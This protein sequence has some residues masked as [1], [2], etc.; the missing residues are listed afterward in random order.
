LNKT[1]F[2]KIKKTESLKPKRGQQVKKNS[3]KMLFA[4]PFEMTIIILFTLILFRKINAVCKPKNRNDLILARDGCLGES[5][6]GNCPIFAARSN[7][8]GCG[9][10]G[11]NGA[12]GDWNVSLVEDMNYMFSS[13]GNFNSDLSKW[14]VGS[15]TDMQYMF[16]QATNFDSDLSKWSVGSVTDM[17]N[18]FYGATNFDSDLSKWS[19]GSVTTMSN[20]FYGAANFNSDLSKWSVGSVTDMSSMF[21]QATKFDPDLSK[22]SVGSVTDMNSMFYQATKFS[23]TLC[24]GSWTESTASKDSMFVGTSSAKIADQPCHCD[25]GTYNDTL[26]NSCSPCPRGRYQDE[27]GY[28]LTECTK[29]CSAGKYSDQQRT[30]SNDDCKSCSPGKWSNEEG[31][32]LDSQCIKCVGG[33][34][35]TSGPG[36]TSESVCKSC[37]GGKYSTSG[38]GQT[39]ESACKSCVGGKYSTSG[40]GQT[41]ESVCKSCVGGKY[42]TSGSGQTSESAC[43]NF[44]SPGKWSNKEGLTSDNDCI[45]CT[46]GKYSTSGKGQT[47]ITVCNNSC[48][49]GRYSTQSGLTSDNQCTACS[50][51]QYSNEIGADKN[52]CKICPAG[53]YVENTGN[54]QCKLCKPGRYLRIDQ[55]DNSASDHSSEEKCL[56]CRENEYQPLEGQKSCQ[57]CPGNLVIEDSKTPNLHYNRSQCYEKGAVPPCANGEGR[58]LQKDGKES[59]C[60]SCTKGTF[61]FENRC[62][63]CPRGKSNPSEKQTSCLRCSDKGTASSLHVCAVPGSTVDPSSSSSSAPS[64]PD[65]FNFLLKPKSDN[66]SDVGMT[67]EALV[68][69]IDTTETPIGKSLIPEEIR[70][71]I[72]TILSLSVFTVIG[73][74]RFFPVKCRTADLLF[75]GDHYIDDTVSFLFTKKSSSFQISSQN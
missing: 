74:H 58:S 13:F 38:S 35:S 11:V 23:P 40:S 45:D 14:S 39:S 44:C 3:N 52:V 2:K 25:R 33:K 34:Y 18:M 41:S 28:I 65:A 1:P 20:M 12:M 64:V 60:Q 57:S 32:T 37:V 30:V 16:M 75:A 24:G 47:S 36:Q 50:K 59:E 10:N 48:T 43:N 21:Y 54:S 55:N 4:T 5:D 56:V 22:W 6:T 62:V 66:D 68:N 63:L 17:S 29:K 8:D 53:Q 31:L 51:G 7:S 71:I 27:S 69:N 67:S 19:V 70:I 15:V 46:K 42:S 9:I 73:T 61:S 49:A 26:T 72:Y